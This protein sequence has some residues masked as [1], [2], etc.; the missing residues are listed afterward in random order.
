MHRYWKIRFGFGSKSWYLDLIRIRMEAY[1][2]WPEN[3][4]NRTR[5]WSF[6]ENWMWIRKK[7]LN[8]TK[9]LGSIYPTLGFHSLTCRS[10]EVGYLSIYFHQHPS[11][12][13]P[14]SFSL[15]NSSGFFSIRKKGESSTKKI[16]LTWKGLRYIFKLKYLYHICFYRWSHSVQGKQ[17]N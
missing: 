3:R 15:N 17:F 16:I 2:S 6:T 1:K 5:M 10:F 4:K 11:H 13:R 7:Y 8:P 12:H 9:I 14:V